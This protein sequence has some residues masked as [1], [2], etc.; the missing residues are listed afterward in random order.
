MVWDVQQKE[1]QYDF[2]KLQGLACTIFPNTYVS[3]VVR[4]QTRN[5]GKSG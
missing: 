1:I 5:A 4:K 3:I 2:D